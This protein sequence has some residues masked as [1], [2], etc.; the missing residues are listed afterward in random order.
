[1]AE[2]TESSKAEMKFEA[3][4]DGV[5]KFALTDALQWFADD[6]WLP[7]HATDQQSAEIVLEAFKRKVTGQLEL[8]DL[9]ILG[10]GD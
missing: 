4:T 5:D 8:L 3:T 2:A 7:A 9:Q 10:N 6:F 1:M